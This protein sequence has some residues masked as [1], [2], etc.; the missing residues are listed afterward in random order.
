M[1]RA[2]LNG[3]T[4]RSR[5]GSLSGQT[6]CAQ[7]FCSGWTF[8]YEP[9]AKG[10]TEVPT[11]AYRLFPALLGTSN[12]RRVQPQRYFRTAR[13]SQDMMQHARKRHPD[14]E[15]LLIFVQTAKPQESYVYSYSD[16]RASRSVM[17][18]ARDLQ[19]SGFVLLVQKRERGGFAYTAIRTSKSNETISF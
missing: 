3:V 13:I 15:A 4:I 1:R 2:A 11:N 10:S 6:D 16:R 7:Q 18:L 19:A 5:V 9:W 14:E 12:R 17:E 8:F